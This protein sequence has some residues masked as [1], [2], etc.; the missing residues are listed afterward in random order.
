[1][2][3]IIEKRELSTL[4]TM[5]H[6]AASSKGTIPVLSGLYLEVDKENGLTMTATDMEIGI[7]SS[8]ANIELIE[9]GS[10]LVNAHYFAD[11]IKLLPDTKISIELNQETAKLNISYGRS[12][13]SIN[14]YR[15][16]EY[17][18]LP[19]S[20]MTYKFSLPQQTLKEALRKTS[21]AAATT[22]FRQV[23]TGVLF[24]ILDNGNINIIASDTHRLAYYKCQ[25]EEPEDN[26]EPF[27]FIIPTRTVNELMRLLDDTEEYIKIAF[28]E[29]NVIFYTDEFMLLSRLIDGQY[30]NYE[31]VIP[32]SFTTTL[33]VDN[34]I[35]ANT[36][37]RAKTMPTDDKLKIQHVQFSFQES[38]AIVNSYSEIMGE[39]EE[40]IEDLDIDGENNYKI[41]FNTNYFL[42]VV[43]ILAGECDE[44]SIQLSG[45]LGPALIKNPEKDNYLYVLVP[46]R[47]SN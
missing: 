11:F 26:L 35:L 8:N 13:G 23:F 1:M 4:T 38:E 21:F 12:A 27:N 42:D 22:H 37:E 20:K 25:V 31:Q 40:I 46:L 19:I 29:N 34:H 18:G 5:V 14:T 6:R 47:T 2:K 36:L 7:K 39:I 16:H 43:K 44:I 30:P 3:L 10:V 32:E 24:D 17:P 9:A 45:A 33:K 28:S 15:D 41:A